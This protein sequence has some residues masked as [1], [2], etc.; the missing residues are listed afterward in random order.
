M[1]WI[2]LRLLAISAI[3]ILSLSGSAKAYTWHNYG[4]H[5]YSLLDGAK[6]WSSAEAEAVS[7]S[8]HLVTINSLAE[9]NWLKSIFGISEYLW[10]GFYQPDGSPEPDGNWQW[11]SGEAV[12]YTHWVGFE[13]NNYLYIENRALM[14]YGYYGDIGWGDYPDSFSVQGIIEKPVPLPGALILLASGLGG[15]AVLRRQLTR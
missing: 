4:G 7:V 12:T 14:N 8:G 5:Q 6:A 13:P 15:L 1:R 9:E 10:I 11:I 3:I 2:P